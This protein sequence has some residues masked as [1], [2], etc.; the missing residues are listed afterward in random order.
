LVLTKL[1]LKKI[2]LTLEHTIDDISQPLASGMCFHLYDYWKHGRNNEIAQKAKEKIPLNILNTLEQALSTIPLDNPIDRM[3][4][5]FGAT[6]REL[7]K[8]E[9]S[10]QAGSKKEIE[11]NAKAKI[12]EFWGDDNTKLSVMVVTSKEKQNLEIC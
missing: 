12:P 4:N 9:A 6:I 10:I 2:D 7:F 11:E 3:I 5:L 1:G 8:I